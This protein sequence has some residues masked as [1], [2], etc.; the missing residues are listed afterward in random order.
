MLSTTPFTVSMS[1]KGIT[2]HGYWQLLPYGRGLHP[3]SH[4]VIVLH[5]ESLH[6]DNNDHTSVGYRGLRLLRADQYIIYLPIIQL[7]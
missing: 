3:A 2:S 6:D 7:T 4:V 5:P 1:A